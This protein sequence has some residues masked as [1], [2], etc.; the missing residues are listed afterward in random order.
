M[1]TKDDLIT[2]YKVTRGGSTVDIEL[3]ANDFD[4]AWKL[5]VRYLRQRHYIGR[6]FKTSLRYEFDLPIDGDNVYKIIPPTYTDY[7]ITNLNGELDIEYSTPQKLEESLRNLVFNEDLR[8]ISSWLIA[9]DY[10]RIARKVRV[11]NFGGFEGATCL[12][13]YELSAEYFNINYL[14]QSA[15][16]I[17]VKY[18]E[19]VLDTILGRI[20]RKYPDSDGEALVS[21]GKEA[22]ASCDED[23]MNY[24]N[25]PVF[26]YV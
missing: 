17:F 25:E 19:G 18:F 13:L 20:R 4:V 26:L 14:K 12:V 3:V 24:L 16:N 2:E 11:T 21:D 9:Y 15:Q 7:R 6:A 23:V 8:N 5:A 1:L 22:M 10:D